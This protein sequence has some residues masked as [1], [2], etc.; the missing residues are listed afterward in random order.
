MLKGGQ[1]AVK[2]ASDRDEKARLIMFSPAQ[3]NFG[4]MLSRWA[5]RRNGLTKLAEAMDKPSGRTEEYSAIA[6]NSGKRRKYPG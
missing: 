3:R 1:F 4:P 2:V 6:A 5:K